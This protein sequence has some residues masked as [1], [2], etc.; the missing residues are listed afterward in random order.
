MS[1]MKLP[2]LLA[3]L[4]I[5]APAAAHAAEGNA[6]AGRVTFVRQCGLCHS[7]R[8]GEVL[9]APS[10]A[11]VIGRKAGAAPGY[12]ASSA[13]KAW[14]KR[15]EAPLL[16][17]YIASPATVVPGTKMSYS[18]L[19]DPTKRADIVAYLSTLR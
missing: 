8:A 12:R 9:T 6:A 11:G 5:L 14:G 4:G 10:L 2:A 15:W 13:L 3:V 1:G 17:A 18:G 16:D 7:P 19:P